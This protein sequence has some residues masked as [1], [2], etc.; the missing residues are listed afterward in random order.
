M[1]YACFVH[2]VRNRLRDL[3]P[4]VLD[5]R[6]GARRDCDTAAEKVIEVGPWVF[7]HKPA[8]VVHKPGWWQAS[9]GKWYP[10]HKHPN[11]RPSPPPP[12]K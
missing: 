3:C 11:Y 5:L 6:S 8:K 7:G 2:R 1:T 9:D 4:L 12:P 10:P